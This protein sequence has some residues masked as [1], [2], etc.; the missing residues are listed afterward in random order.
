MFADIRRA[1]ALTSLDTETTITITYPSSS[2]VVVPEVEAVPVYYVSP[3]YYVDTYTPVTI[4]S[5]VP[6]Y[7][8]S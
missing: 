1:H 7:V 2:E 5:A 3:V 6:I 8:I 4:D